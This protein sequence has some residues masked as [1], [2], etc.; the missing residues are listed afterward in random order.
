MEVSS[1]ELIFKPQAPS[2]PTGTA[3]VD[4]VIQGY[5]LSITNLEPVAYSYA[6]SFVAVPPP[7]GTPNGVFRSLAGN[8]LVFVDVPGA[9]NQ[10]G[11]LTGTPGGSTFRPSTGLIRVPAKATALVAVLPS[12]FGPVP[13]DPT[14]LTMP[15]FEVRGYVEITLPALSRRVPPLPIPFFTVA[16]SERPV[17]VL[18]TPQNRATFL[19]ATGAIS[20]QTQASLPLATG[21]AVNA[22][23]P[24]PGGPLVLSPFNLE[25]ELP[26]IT[27]LLEA[28]PEV[29]RAAMLAALIGQIDPATADLGSFNK[30]LAE[31]SVPLAIERRAARAE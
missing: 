3:A 30:A 13:G 10:Q 20:D 15:V 21:R 17:R 23:A 29:S 26:P 16:Q 28:M 27:N 25:R 6:V 5:F 1:F 4:R 22:I 7:A 14:P 9:D 8:T 19:T 12:A 24:E 31:A 11:I 2:A 18:L